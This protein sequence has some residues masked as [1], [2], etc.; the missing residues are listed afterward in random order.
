MKKSMN[1]RTFHRVIVMKE[2]LTKWYNRQKPSTQGNPPRCRQLT[3]IQ[4]ATLQKASK[5]LSL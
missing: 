2:R 1:R 3:K 4:K 5:E